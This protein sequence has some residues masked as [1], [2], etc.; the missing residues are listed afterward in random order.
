M[1]CILQLSEL[2]SIPWLI[3][4]EVSKNLDNRKFILVPTYTIEKKEKSVNKA[5]SSQEGKLKKEIFLS[6]KPLRKV[7]RGSELFT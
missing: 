5:Q 6:L 1:D 4:I 7:M 2:R 3:N